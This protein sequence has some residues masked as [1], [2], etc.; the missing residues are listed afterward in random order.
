MQCT[1]PRSFQLSIQR[2]DSVPVVSAGQRSFTSAQE[3]WTWLCTQLPTVQ[4]PVSVQQL[5]SVRDYLSHGGDISRYEENS[6]RK[7]APLPEGTSHAECQQA[8]RELGL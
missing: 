7:E 5:E 6:R 8:L 2:V 4:A 3:L 1:E